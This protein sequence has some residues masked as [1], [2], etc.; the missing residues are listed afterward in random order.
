MNVP[1]HYPALNDEAVLRDLFARN[2]GN[3][4]MLGYVCDRW[5]LLVDGEKDRQE[6]MDKLTAE[7]EGAEILVD[8][9][10]K[11]IDSLTREIATL[12]RDVGWWEA[13]ADELQKEVEHLSA[14]LDV[15]D[16]FGKMRE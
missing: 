3:N 15:C 11:E 12:E 6:E 9:K 14:Q 10:Q 8:E 4:P 16:P 1:T 2:Y 5:E 7:K 13:K